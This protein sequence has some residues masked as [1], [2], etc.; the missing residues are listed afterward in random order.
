PPMPM[1]R[2][3]GTKGRP[4]LPR[5]S[6]APHVVAALRPAIL[7][8]VPMANIASDLAIRHGLGGDRARP[9]KE[10]TR[11]LPDPL[12]ANSF[13]LREEIEVKTKEE[14]IVGQ[15]AAIRKVL[16][17]AEQVAATGTPVLLLGETGTGKELLARALHARSARHVR[18]MVALNCAAL[19]A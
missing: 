18:P 7:E 19:P 12:Q 17:Q 8:T 11:R 1:V 6:G 14:E 15:S 3:A 9:Y 16:L 2:A 13:C 4:S 5:Q 10:T